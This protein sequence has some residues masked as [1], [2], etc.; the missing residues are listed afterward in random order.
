MSRT[1]YDDTSSPKEVNALTVGLA[2]KL[3]GGLVI[4]ALIFGFVTLW[5]GV[6]T[7]DEGYVGVVKRNGAVIDI[8]DPGLHVKIPYIDTMDEMEV[9][10][11]AAHLELTGS[12][13][14]P[15]LIP[16][17]ATINWVANKNSIKELYSEYGSL[18]QFEQRVLLPAF[19]DA[20][21]AATS[22]Y[23]VNE[24]LRDR[25]KF[26]ESAANYV[27]MKT[28]SRVMTVTS[29][30][31]VDV[32]FPDSYEKQV[33]DKQVAAEAALT[34]EYKLKQ[35]ALVARQVT[36]TAEAE[37]DAAKARADGEA[38]KIKTEGEAK[39]QAISVTGTSLAKNPLVVEYEK[40]KTWGGHFPTTFMGGDQA[41]NT[42]WSLPGSAPKQ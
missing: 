6:Y 9:R 16:V 41:A 35:Q 28:P 33:L 8:T 12:S 14:D 5:L 4:T 39:A 40:V 11:R 17:K 31:I 19:N 34:E 1:R 37:R 3:G 2:A 10:E 22:D 24:L 7:V 15:M 38:Y 36:Q 21:K 27:K 29:V 18:E 23:S 13:S 20:I 25:V 26:G 32:D 30:F 42:L